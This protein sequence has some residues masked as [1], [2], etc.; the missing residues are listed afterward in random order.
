MSMR[1]EKRV[2]MAMAMATMRARVTRAS[3]SDEGEQR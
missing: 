1:M 3:G 2:A